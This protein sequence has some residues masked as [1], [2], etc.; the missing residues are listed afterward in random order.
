MI[1]SCVILFGNSYNGNYYNS[2]NTTV[3]Y[4][5]YTDV[6]T[7]IAIVQPC[8]T[9]HIRLAI[10]DG[11]DDFLDS[12]VFLE[13]NSFTATS[14][15]IDTNAVSI[16]SDTLFVECIDSSLY[17]EAGISN[18][19]YSVLWNTGDTSTSIFV[20]PGQY[21]YTANNGSC[22]LSSDTVTIFNQTIIQKNIRKMGATIFY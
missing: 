2:G 15:S 20:G 22:S 16:I 3:S 9:Y 7:A 18:S 5:G 8:Q 1:S 6:F 4:N 17:L 14:V 12:G 21:F 19:N 13:A 10:A 11:S